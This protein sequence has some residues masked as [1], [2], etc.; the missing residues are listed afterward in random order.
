M[1]RLIFTADNTDGFSDDDLDVLND[2]LDLLLGDTSDLDDR[3][4]YQWSRSYGDAINNAWTGQ[5]TAEQLAADA[6]K[7]LS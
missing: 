5:D 6:R 3:E 4:L 2:A 7:L 1:D